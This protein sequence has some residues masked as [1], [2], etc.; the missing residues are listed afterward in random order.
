MRKATLRLQAAAR[1][2]AVCAL[3]NDVL[4]DLRLLRNGHV[5]IKFSQG[6]GPPR[7]SNPNAHPNPNPNPNL[8]PNPN[9]NPNPRPSPKP[10]PN[11]KPSPNPYSDPYPN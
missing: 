7:D 9:P 8:N 11:P 3:T 1:R 5:F 6:D 10:N 4:L 2:Y